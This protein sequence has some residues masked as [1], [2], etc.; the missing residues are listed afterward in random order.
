MCWE[1]RAAPP[2]SAASPSGGATAAIAA[3]TPKTYEG[4]ISV[5]A[6]KSVTIPF[7]EG[8]TP[9]AFKLDPKTGNMVS[10]DCAYSLSQDEFS[11]MKP[12]CAG[13]C[14]L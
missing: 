6:D 12:P 7:G 9:V 10:K 11:Q 14:K 3:A 13:E 5:A 4:G 2:V 8:G 1:Y